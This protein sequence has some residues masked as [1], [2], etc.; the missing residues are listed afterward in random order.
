MSSDSPEAGVE[1]GL[2]NY[3]RSKGVNTCSKVEAG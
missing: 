2:V 1:L 3:L